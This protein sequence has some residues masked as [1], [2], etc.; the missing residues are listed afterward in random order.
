MGCLCQVPPQSSSMLGHHRTK[1]NPDPL[2]SQSHPHNMSLA[3]ASKKLIASESMQDLYKRSK[4]HPGSCD[5]DSPHESPS[6]TPPPPYRGLVGMY[7]TLYC[8]RL[9]YLIKQSQ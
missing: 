2:G 3:E 9:I 8:Q 1:S 7:L 5:V 4:S 6:G